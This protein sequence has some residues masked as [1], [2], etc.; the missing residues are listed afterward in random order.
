M[1]DALSGGGRGL[2]WD[3]VFGIDYSFILW[4]LS[5]M[6]GVWCDDEG[7]EWGALFLVLFYIWNMYELWWIFLVM[8]EWIKNKFWNLIICQVQSN[9]L[10]LLFSDAENFINK[11]SPCLYFLV[12][13]KIVWTSDQFNNMKLLTVTPS[14][15][16]RSVGERNKLCSE[17][18][19]FWGLSLYGLCYSSR[20]RGHQ[21]YGNSW[22]MA[23][24]NNVSSTGD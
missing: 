21:N 13:P 5:L 14:R 10:S 1:L 12:V 4:N 15:R 18:I 20:I 16:S 9:P 24:L 23:E 11:W 22:R 2:I 19:L 8:F 17:L 3:L 7:T 6:F